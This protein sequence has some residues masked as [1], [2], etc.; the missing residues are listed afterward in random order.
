MNYRERGLA[1]LL[2]TEREQT[3]DNPDYVLGVMD[4]LVTV[5]DL[6]KE[7]IKKYKEQTYD[8]SN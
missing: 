5:F 7:E 2:K 3:G 1:F 6:T 4:A 8:S